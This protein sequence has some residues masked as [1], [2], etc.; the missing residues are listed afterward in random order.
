MIGGKRVLAIVPARKGSKRLKDKNILPLMGKPLIAWTLD[1]AKESYYID[2]I[3][4]STDSQIICDIALEKKVHCPFLRPKELAKDTATTNDVITHVVEY[5]ENNG[6]FY[7]YIMLLQPT[8]PLRTTCD[9]D[10][11]I[12]KIYQMDKDT[13]VSMSR[14]DHPPILTNVLPENESLEGF[15]KKEN[16]V[17]SQDLPTYYRINGALYIF[18]RSYVGKLS[19][20]YNDKGIA[21]IS[22]EGTDVD[23]DTLQDFKF[24]EYLI[25]NKMSK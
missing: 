19:D 14:C 16:N 10:A 9:I 5:L 13:L 24:A 1:A 23:I 22:T 8:S 20:I 12:E 21:F 15:L 6:D 17:R 3:F 11:A 7:D 4:V 2:N 25:T 18:K